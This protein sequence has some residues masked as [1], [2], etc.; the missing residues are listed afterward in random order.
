MSPTEAIVALRGLTSCHCRPA[1]GGTKHLP[2][3]NI[4]YRVDVD[5]LAT[6]ILTL[7]AACF[8]AQEV[9]RDMIGSYTLNPDRVLAVLRGQP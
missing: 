5:I 6:M 2:S 7:E 4:E 9:G 8:R 3:C 1:R